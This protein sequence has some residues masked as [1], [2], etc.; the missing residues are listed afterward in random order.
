MNQKQINALIRHLDNFYLSQY[1]TE[2]CIT[3]GKLPFSDRARVEDDSHGE[4][5]V[6]DEL[7]WRTPPLDLDW[8]GFEDD[9]FH[10]ERFQNMDTFT[11]PQSA[12]CVVRGSSYPLFNGPNTKMLVPLTPN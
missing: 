3:A 9:D 10:G 6:E 4:R 8:E 5:I 1:F 2:A 12:R 7:P 11:G